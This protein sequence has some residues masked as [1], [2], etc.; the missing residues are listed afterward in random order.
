MPLGQTAVH[1]AACCT[2]NLR[3][4][5][6]LGADVNERD[7]KGNTA[8]HLACMTTSVYTPISARTAS[9][10]QLL[11]ASADVSVYSNNHN[12]KPREGCWPPIHYA[13]VTSHFA[14]DA[15]AVIDLLISHGASINDRTTLGCTPAWLVARHCGKL[16]G[17]CDYLQMLFDRGADANDYSLQ[18]GSLLHAA[19]AGGS[20]DVLLM[21]LSKGL[22]VCDDAQEGRTDK[23]LTALHCAAQASHVAVVQLL[24][25]RGADLTATTS[26]GWTVLA[27][28]LQGPRD[29]AACCSLLVE[30]GCDALLVTN[31]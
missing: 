29:A 26:A 21:L 22:A 6:E 2:H 5:I 18:S 15:C 23:R 3:Q 13:A 17:V 1:L 31:R 4:L 28:C 25:D 11:D 27:M 24:I 19:A 7:F 9:V 10:Q 30:A 14:A 16:L 20:V 8:L 12:S